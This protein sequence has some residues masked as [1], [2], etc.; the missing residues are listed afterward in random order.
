MADH[1]DP[2]DH[3][4]TKSILTFRNLD[5]IAPMYAPS[6]DEWFD[7]LSV[8]NT[9]INFLIVAVIAYSVKSNRPMSSSRVGGYRVH[10]RLMHERRRQHSE[11]VQFGP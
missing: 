8:I 5:L 2:P 10:R 4:L 9:N 1:R 3:Q 7:F 6:S 11:Y